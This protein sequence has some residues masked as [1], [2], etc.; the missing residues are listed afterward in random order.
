MPA[1]LAEKPIDTAAIAGNFP[2][3]RGFPGE[4]HPTGA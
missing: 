4:T 1:Y 2:T 3:L